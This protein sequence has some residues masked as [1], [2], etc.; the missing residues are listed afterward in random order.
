MGKEIIIDF[1]QYDGVTAE[2]LFLIDPKYCQWI[3]RQH[4]FKKSHPNLVDTLNKMFEENPGV[5]NY[6]VLDFGPYYG[7]KVKDII[8]DKNYCKWLINRNKSFKHEYPKM[9]SE[10][11]NMYNL[12]YGEKC[13]YLYVL[14]FK[15]EDVDYIKI[16]KTKQSIVRRMYNYV[17]G[18]LSDYSEKNVDWSKSFVYKTNRLSAEKDLFLLLDK[19]R[20]DKKTEKF[21]LDALNEIHSEIRNLTHGKYYF[22]KKMLSDFIPFIDGNEWRNCF[23]VPI[24]AFQDFE[25]MYLELLGDLGLRSLYNPEFLV[26]E[27]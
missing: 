23:Y 13:I 18:Y 19:Y 14:C 2:E 7:M 26:C 20:L 8:N 4:G 27:N 22:N 21:H 1:G 24:N 25:R 11:V 9:Y 12:Y 3:T 16:G 10:L 5:L 6:D 17:Y 15:D